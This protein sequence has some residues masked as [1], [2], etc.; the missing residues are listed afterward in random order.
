MLSVLYLLETYLQ[1]ENGDNKEV[2]TIAYF[3]EEFCKVLKLN[4]IQFASHVDTDVS[5]S[6]SILM[7]GGHLIL[8]L[9]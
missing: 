9:P 4:K 1:E 2:Y 8:N 3:I 6:I 5:H 7:G